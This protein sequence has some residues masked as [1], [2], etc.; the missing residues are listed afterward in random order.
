MSTPQD[1]GPACAIR[2]HA[3]PG[4][5]VRLHARNHSLVAEGQTSYAPRAEHPSALDYLLAAL[6]SDLVL[7]L[8][9]EAVRAGVTLDDIELNVTAHLD[10][11]LVA[12]GVVG[13]TGSA[14][15]AVV[16]G[17]LYVSADLT[18]A[19]LCDLWTRVLAKATVHAT[20]AAC[21]TFDIALKL[22]P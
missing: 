1:A 2:A 15:V 3:A 10:N 19:A 14:R 12:L 13:E 20:L 6:A 16:R 22:V 8:G 9:R 5:Q 7:G 4:G 18:E 17:S 21:I 11:P